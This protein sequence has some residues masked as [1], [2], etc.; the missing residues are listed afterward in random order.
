[1]SSSR[2]LTFAAA[3]LFR[4]KPRYVC[5]EHVAPCTA[6]RSFTTAA[7][8]RSSVTSSLP[9]VA[10]PSTWSSIIPK[11]FR[12]PSDPV[13]LAE[14]QKA[15]ANRSKEWNPATFYIVMS[16]LIGSMAINTIALKK[17]TLNFS[18]KAEAKLT[19]L[20]EVVAR[21]QKGEDVDVEG[22]LGTGNEEQEKEWEGVLQEIENED[23]LWQ[24]RRKK[25]E[26]KARAEAADETDTSKPVA[27]RRTMEEHDMTQKADNANDKP[28]RPGFY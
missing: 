18:R 19:L 4:Y 21:V 22:L 27:D 6:T 1:M 11:A 12:T 16:L 7:S 25:Q 23:A 15:R 13:A 10:Q 24:T 20:R 9:K 2:Q 17:E 8:L 5:S 14:R 26:A 28:R 3:R